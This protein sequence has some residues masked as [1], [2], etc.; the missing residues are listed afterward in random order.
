M[1]VRA[2]WDGP[3]STSDKY[4]RLVPNKEYTVDEADVASSSF[5]PVVPQEIEEDKP[6][7]KEVKKNG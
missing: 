2:T 3:E 7:I 5:V 6:E 4:G 1:K